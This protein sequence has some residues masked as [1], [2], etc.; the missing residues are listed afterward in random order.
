M[1]AFFQLNSPFFN[2]PFARQR[3]LLPRATVSLRETT[4]HRP[5]KFLVGVPRL[6]WLY[7]PAAD[8]GRVSVSEKD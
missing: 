4:I 7:G 8:G 6:R 1:T 3:L 5:M 2:E